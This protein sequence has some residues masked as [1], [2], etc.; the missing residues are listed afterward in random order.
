LALLHRAGAET[1]G[2]SSKCTVK[3][4]CEGQIRALSD[5]NVPLLVYK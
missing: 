3:W 4:R 1:S 2:T 5:M